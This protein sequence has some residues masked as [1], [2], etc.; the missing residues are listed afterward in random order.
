MA[1]KTYIDNVTPIDAASMNDI[2][3]HV[4][5]STPIS[6][7]TTVHPA[8]TIANTPAG[9]IASTNV[10][11]ALNELDTEKA[12]LAG[13][14]TQ[15][16]QVAPATTGT[17]A[18]QFQQFTASS[19][20][21]NIGF[22]QSGTG[23]VPM[24]LQAVDREWVSA[25]QYGAVGDG[26]TDDTTAIQNAENT[27][28]MVYFPKPPAFYNTTAPINMGYHPVW[29]GDNGVTTIIRRTNGAGSVLDFLGSNEGGSIQ[30]L[31]IGGIGS[32]G[33]TVA[34][35]GY[36]NYLSTLK[37]QNVNFE[38]DL[39]V[40][41]NA[42][43]IHN[44]FADCTFGYYQQTSVN[45][46]LQ[47]I[48]S[49][50][51]GTNYT[52]INLLENCKF[53]NGGTT[54]DAVSFTA[55]VLLSFKNCS[56][57]NNGRDLLTNNMSNVTL[58]NCYTE[59][60]KHAT[61]QFDF[62]TSRTRAVV[63]GG[64][65]NGGGMPTGASMFRASNDCPLLVEDA[66]ISVTAA[67]FCY[68]NATTTL[69]S[70]PVSSVHHFKDIRI[71][72]NASDPLLYLDNLLEGVPQTWTPT[73]QSGAT[74]TF[75]LLNCHYV[76]IGN[77]CIVTGRITYPITADTSQARI[78]LPFSGYQFSGSLCSSYATGI[79]IFGSTNLLL[80]YPDGQASNITNA[81]LSGKELDISVS[82]IIQ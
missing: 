48:V 18:P 19:G 13:S 53:F 45:A 1:N 6:P 9:N 75:T 77:M 26:T 31:R 70:L 40:C 32:T 61:S 62:T 20:S 12:L 52:N 15:T 25:T 16:F 10:Q 24:T 78:G 41:I 27:G 69:H 11:A 49:S 50:Y 63:R 42:D 60:G 17:M 46:N 67:A 82:F 2:N 71:Q 30:N 14:P 68:Q 8:S 36:T 73:D 23:A 74:L 47:H 28:K 37:L 35:G 39:L 81:N 3:N 38:A 5:S 22:I 29:F 33:I 79:Y 44:H 34:G 72:G 66:D 64:Q 58:D 51:S 59:R 65:F 54:K 76:K 43:L 80:F 21:S 56:W 57:E 55:G 4:Y 7:A